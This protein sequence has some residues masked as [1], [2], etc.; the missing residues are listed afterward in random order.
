MTD[1]VFYC[2]TWSA[3]RQKCTPTQLE[4][5]TG[6]TQVGGESPTQYHLPKGHLG[7]LSTSLLILSSSLALSQMHTSI[8]A[9]FSSYH[10]YRHHGRNTIGRRITQCYHEE[11]AFM[12]ISIG[13][14]SRGRFDDT[15]SQSHSNIFL[16]LFFWIGAAGLQLTAIPDDGF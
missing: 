12:T 14:K 2:S 3:V 7:P 5:S 8:W 11:I 6:E 10:V 4:Q 13:G 1:D 15:N 16:M 9:I